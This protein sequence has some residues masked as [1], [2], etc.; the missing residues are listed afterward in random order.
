MTSASW[1]REVAYRRL[2]ISKETLFYP[3]TIIIKFKIF[4]FLFLMHLYSVLNNVIWNTII[5]YKQH[6]TNPEW[7][8]VLVFWTTDL[9]IRQS[10]F[11][12]PMTAMHFPNMLLPKKQ[13]NIKNSKLRFTARLQQTL[14]KTKSYNKMAHQTK[15]IKKSNIEQD[16]EYSLHKTY[17]TGS[18][19]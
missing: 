19:I 15:F 5:Q 8:K 4:I 12:E 2:L 13:Q 9:G 18:N 6:T 16:G 3:I 10:C 7:N 17:I 11:I 14:K 1:R